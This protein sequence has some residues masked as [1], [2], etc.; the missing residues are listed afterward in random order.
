MNAVLYARVSSDKQAEKD[1]SIPAQLKSL[2]QYALARKWNVV[3]EFIDEA[4][5]ARTADRP[6]FQ[7]M[8]AEAKQKNQP[9]SA[10]LVWKLNR[11]ARNRED[12]IIYK[13]LLRRKGIQVISIN[14]QIDDTASGKLLEGLLE[15]IDEFYSSNLAQDTVRGMKENAARGF[16]NGGRGAF[17]YRI[18]KISAN[19]QEK[20]TYEISEAEA[21][22]VR[23]IFK[24][25]VQGEGTKDIAKGI[26]KKGYR[27]RTGKEWRSN[28]VAYVLRNEAYTGTIVW[29]LT[30]RNGELRKKKPSEEVV[31]IPNAFPAIISKETFD[32]A[33]KA[34]AA[35]SPKLIHPRVISSNH[36]LSGLIKCSKCGSNF[37]A[38]TAK[39]GKYSYFMCQGSNKGSCKQ[40]ALSIDKFE[41][42]TVNILKE[43]V[44]TEENL[45]KLLLMVVDE[46]QVF[47]K[48][49]EGKLK[50]FTSLIEERTKR[51]DRLFETIETA[52]VELTDIAPRLK[53]LNDE[54]ADYK[55]QREYLELK[56]ERGDYPKPTEEN[57]KP[58]VADL[59]KTLLK[60][61]LFER[62]SFI[63][64]FIKQ[65][66]IEYPHAVIEYTIPLNKESENP[67]TEVLAFNLNGSPRHT[68]ERPFFE[69]EFPISLYR[70][71]KGAWRIGDSDHP[72][73]TSSWPLKLIASGVNVPA[74]QHV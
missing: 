37:S 44:L 59:Q 12:S 28:N 5:S 34:I 11:F 63:R 64:S 66:I 74:A 36:L 9:F 18:K 35:R 2:R 48:E 61:S 53:A 40:K 71:L 10:I 1:L 41:A 3:K 60:G 15:V 70:T 17:G 7:E 19:G 30:N 27:K 42:F 62:K 50:H 4:E 29:N 32:Q 33:Q 39:S 6:A 56:L 65:I 14:E 24:L 69:V 43:R 25:C 58:Y 22:I 55:R 8:I 73:S 47:R 49:Y 21:P 23:E 52:R 57:M 46:F 51:R 38:C 31:R 13:S 72:H 45:K 67:R 20:R 54:I 26:N 68:P 16:L